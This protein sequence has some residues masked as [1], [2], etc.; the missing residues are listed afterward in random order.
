MW[1]WTMLEIILT[2]RAVCLLPAAK[3]LLVLLLYIYREGGCGFRFPFTTSRH[4]QKLWQRREQ[5]VTFKSPAL[6]HVQAPAPPLQLR[7]AV[8]LARVQ[9]IAKA[10]QQAS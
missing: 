10:L 7:C 5:L 2:S 3:L 8:L 9:Q 1:T 6:V 4:L